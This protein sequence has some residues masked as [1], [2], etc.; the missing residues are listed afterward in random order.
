MTSQRPRNTTSLSHLY[1]ETVCVKGFQRCLKRSVSCIK[2]TS[3]RGKGWE[4]CF[5]LVLK[6]FRSVT[7]A[8]QRIENAHIVFMTIY[9]SPISILLGVTS[10]LHLWPLWCWT[11]ACFIPAISAAQLLN[12]Y[13]TWPTSTYINIGS[14]KRNYWLLTNY[15]C[16]PTWLTKN[17]K[18]ENTMYIK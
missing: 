1:K 18:E 11:S 9:D 6:L 5:V 7:P 8:F 2:S 15:N 12:T 10:L 17:L 16:N 3:E 4:G 13:W 14:A